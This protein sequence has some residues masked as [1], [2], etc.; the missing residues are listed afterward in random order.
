MTGKK[1]LSVMDAFQAFKADVLTHENYEPPYDAD[2]IVKMVEVD[3]ELEVDI[4]TK[5]GFF[6]SPGDAEN[7]VSAMREVLEAEGIAVEYVP[8]ERH[9]EEPEK[10]SNH[11]GLKVSLAENQDMLF[12]VMRAH[13]RYRADN[14]ALSRKFQI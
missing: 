13:E 10:W 5:R 9:A 1:K 8:D 14:P 11:P 3:H 12:K 7:V 6:A 4:D 2:E